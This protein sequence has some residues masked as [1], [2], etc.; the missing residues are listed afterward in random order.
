MILQCNTLSGI[1]HTCKEHGKRGLH[2]CTVFVSPSNGFPTPSL[3]FQYPVPDGSVLK[4][5][6]IGKAIMLLYRHP[7]EA[8]KNKEKAGK[9]ISKSPSFADRLRERVCGL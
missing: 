2:G 8:K 1:E 4:S 7:K 6:K 3:P 5:S 9:I